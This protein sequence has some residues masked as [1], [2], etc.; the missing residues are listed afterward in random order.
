VMGH[1]SSQHMQVNDRISGRVIIILVM[2]LLID[3]LCQTVNVPY[4]ERPCEGT[5]AAAAGV[6]YQE[7]DVQDHVYQAV[8][9]QSYNTFRVCTSDAWHGTFCQTSRI[10]LLFNVG[11]VHS[12]IS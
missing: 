7:D 12:V 1:Y 8:L 2:L 11:S 3:V 10:I 4:I 5:T 6:E 9:R